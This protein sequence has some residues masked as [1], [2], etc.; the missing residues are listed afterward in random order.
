MMPAMHSIL[1]SHEI[2]YFEKANERLYLSCFFG[3]DFSFR[4]AR[5]FMDLRLIVNY[6]PVF[7]VENFAS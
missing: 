6:W 7:E 3:S 5:L 4:V 2:E 1:L